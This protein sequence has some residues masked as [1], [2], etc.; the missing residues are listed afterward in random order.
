MCNPLL[1]LL[2]NEQIDDI[3][4]SF[5]D[6]MIWLGSHS[7]MILLLI[8]FAT[9]KIQMILHET[10]LDIIM[11]EL[12]LL[13]S[14]PIVISAISWFS[15]DWH[16]RC[17]IILLSW[18]DDCSSLRSVHIR[19]IMLSLSSW[20]CNRSWSMYC[21]H[22]WEWDRDPG[23]IRSCCSS[24]KYS[25]SRSSAKVFL[26]S[27]FIMMGPSCLLNMISSSCPTSVSDVFFFLTWTVRDVWSFGLWR[28]LHLNDSRKYVHSQ[29]FHQDREY[30]LLAD[31]LQEGDAHALR[32]FRSFYEISKCPIVNVIS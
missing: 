30:G 13:W 28:I 24:R 8:Y 17:K 15:N 20:I 19:M 4:E 16:L 9:K 7:L 1:E 25:R 3:C 21:I 31:R 6:K 29:S 5:N 26:K 27:A 22:L 12:Y 2:S 11:H 18:Y 32:Q 10:S 23:G 14:V